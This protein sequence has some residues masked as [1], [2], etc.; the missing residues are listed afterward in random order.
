MKQTILIVDDSQFD[1][2]L[3][4]AA[5][6]KKS[7]FE[8]LVAGDGKECMDILTSRPVHLVLLDIMLPDLNGDQVLKKIRDRWNPIELP[9]IMVTSKSQTQDV[10]NCLQDGANDFITKP[11]LFDVA[12]SRMLTHLRLSEVSRKMGKMSEI[13]AVNAMI[14]TYHHEINNP[15]TIALYCAEN[16]DPNDPERKKTLTDALWRI[17][18]IVKKIKSVSEKDL[19]FSDYTDLSK[20]IKI[21]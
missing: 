4:T 19:E 1:R 21:D 20:M 7:D 18:D 10:I 15:L 6:S 13:L 14:T 8:L 12:V 5:L 17:A 11:V 2:N 3:L 16:G 9:V